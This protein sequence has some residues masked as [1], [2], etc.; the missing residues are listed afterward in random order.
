MPIRSL[1]TACAAA[2]VLFLT[3]CASTTAYLGNPNAQVGVYRD[4]IDLNGHLSVTYQKDG[5]PQS[6]SGSFT[7]TQQPGR[8][9]VSLENPLGQTIAEIKVTPQA[10]T[11]TQS[12]RPPREARDIDTLTAQAIGFPLPVSGLRDWLQGYATDAQGKRFV[13]SP[14]NNSVVT[15]DGWRLTFVA[16]QAQAPGGTAAP[17]PRR[18]DV[19]RGSSANGDALDIHVILDPAG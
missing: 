3:G 8:I 9:E 2:G 17:A 12:N 11:L 13:A 19:S 18:I 1:L 14:G 16:W 7:W 6:L 10:A 15:N 5:Q 4:T